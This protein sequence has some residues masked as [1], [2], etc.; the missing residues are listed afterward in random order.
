[1]NLEKLKSCL[2]LQ[3]LIVKISEKFLG[4]GFRQP[5]SPESPGGHSFICPLSFEKFPEELPPLIFT[6]PVT[7]IT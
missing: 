1:M 5:P 7:C 2:E 3:F 4:L 6:H